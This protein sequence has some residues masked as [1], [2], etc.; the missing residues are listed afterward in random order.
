MYSKNFN[1]FLKNQIGVVTTNNG[2]C[3]TW[4]S[5]LESKRFKKVDGYQKLS[6]EHIKEECYSIWQKL[7]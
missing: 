7:V 6:D 4:F 3:V 1:T 5:R 2:R